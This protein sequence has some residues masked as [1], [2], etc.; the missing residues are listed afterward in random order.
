MTTVPMRVLLV[1]DDDA[2]LALI[3]EAFEGHRVPARLHVA[4][5]G[6]E[7]LD[8]LHS[9]AVRPD[10]I[11]LDLNMPRM[12]GREVLAA[13]KQD[14]ALSAIPVVVFTTS[15]QPD[16]ITASYLRHANA[17]VTK[18]MELDDFTAAVDSIHT[19]Y[20]DLA[21]RSPGLGTGL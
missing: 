21:V 4:R 6:V 5:D 17:Y 18:P 14:P 16:D 2:D 9:G 3:T 15:D 13:V 20:G 7:A 11:L 19:F 10:M 8:Y 1:D 12:D